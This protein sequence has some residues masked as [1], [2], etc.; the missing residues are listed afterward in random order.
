MKDNNEPGKLP[1]PT[2][3]QGTPAEPK[4]FDTPTS[5]PLELGSTNSDKNSG[6]KSSSGGFVNIPSPITNP[7][8]KYRS[9]EGDRDRLANN[10]TEIPKMNFIEIPESQ[11]KALNPKDEELDGSRKP[12]G[13][14]IPLML[15]GDSILTMQFEEMADKI[16]TEKES[17]AGRPKIQ[18][19]SGWENNRDGQNEK[20]VFV[21]NS[22]PKTSKMESM[23]ASIININT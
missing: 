14:S 18:T 17:Y 8:N 6:S 13:Q 3:L 10:T 23:D 19:K 11:S 21:I 2:Y 4:L 20:D 16:K 9:S 1:T 22:L 5:P 12:S 15:G 7:L